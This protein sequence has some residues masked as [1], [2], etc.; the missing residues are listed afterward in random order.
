MQPTAPE[1]QLLCDII[2]AELADR[3]EGT[4]VTKDDVRQVVEKLTGTTDI[5]VKFFELAAGG[6][7]CEVH[8]K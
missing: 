3:F 5:E 8:F 2:Q 4:V 1:D 7:R 6:S